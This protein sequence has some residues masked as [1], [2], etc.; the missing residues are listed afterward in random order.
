[1]QWMMACPS[2]LG[3]LQ[4]CTKHVHCP[5][6]GVGWGRCWLFWCLCDT[7]MLPQLFSR[8]FCLG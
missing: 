5:V 8:A 6:A 2:W 1:M 3:C 4:L 7:V